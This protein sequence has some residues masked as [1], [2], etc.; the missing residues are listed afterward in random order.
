VRRSILIVAVQVQE[1]PDEQRYEAV[2]DGE[3]AGFTAY[4]MQPGLISFV[5]T[6]V[7]DAF[8]GRGVGSILIREALEDVRRRGFEVLPFCPFVNSFIAEHREF[9]D[10]VPGS[11]REEFGL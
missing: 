2:V 1:N 10:L 4:R 8:E 7:Q 9:A 3:V 11:R 6:E 5:H